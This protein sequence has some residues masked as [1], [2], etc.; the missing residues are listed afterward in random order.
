MCLCV[1][2]SLCLCVCVCSCASAVSVQVVGVCASSAVCCVCR[3]WACVLC[4]CVRWWAC[5][6]RQLCVCVCAVC[7]CV[8]VRGLT[9]RRL[10]SHPLAGSVA[11]S[12]RQGPCVDAVS[13]AHACVDAV[14]PACV[15]A[16]SPADAASP[17][18]A[19]SGLVWMPGRG[20]GCG[21]APVVLA[22]VPVCASCARPCLLGV[23]G[24]SVWACRA[25]WG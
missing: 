15:D 8:R 21:G 11:H 18:H 9:P 2:V 25:F 3:W 13:P 14:S 16:V 12:R 19:A 17:A 24:R 1:C 20:G 10:Q 22:S 4:A 7:V 23:S 5:A 6:R